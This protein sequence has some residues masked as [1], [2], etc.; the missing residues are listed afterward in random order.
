MLLGSG[1]HHTLGKSFALCQWVVAGARQTPQLAESPMVLA[2]VLGQFRLGP[3][4]PGDMSGF[5]SSGGA[6][7]GLEEG[8]LPPGP[9]LRACV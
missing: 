7:L 3:P 6:R 2:P 9:L 4:A 1:G 5:P 8:A